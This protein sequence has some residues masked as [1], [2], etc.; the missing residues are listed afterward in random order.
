MNLLGKAI[1]NDP[2]PDLRRRNRT[3]EGEESV[4]DIVL[5]HENCAE[6][7]CYDD[8][9]QLHRVRLS[10]SEGSNEDR[11]VGHKDHTEKATI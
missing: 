7:V 1:Y 4:D 9:A 6:E 2:T 5:P 8:L 3:K 10:L 11:Y